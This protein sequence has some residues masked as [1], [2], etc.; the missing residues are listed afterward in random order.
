[1]M[2][3][4][5]RLGVSQVSRQPYRRICPESKLVDYFIIV[6]VYLSQMDGMKAAG[7]VPIRGLYL[8]TSKIEIA[9]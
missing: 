9:G 7:L 3:E 5:S 6:I 8:W 2:T 1:M 4:R